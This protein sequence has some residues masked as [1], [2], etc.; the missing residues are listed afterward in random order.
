VGPAGRVSGDQQL[1]LDLPGA[2]AGAAGRASALDG[3][4]ASSGAAER[5]DDRRTLYL[6][7]ETARQV[8][9]DAA[10]APGRAVDGP[11]VALGD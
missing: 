10:R 1:G 2:E 8:E 4:R 5:Q 6:G 11:D 9:F 7:V 3:R